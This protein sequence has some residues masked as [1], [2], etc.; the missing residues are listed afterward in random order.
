[1]A[2]SCCKFLIG[3][4]AD[5][6]VSEPICSLVNTKLADVDPVVVW[7]RPQS[8]GFENGIQLEE[9]VGVAGVV[10]SGRQT[11]QCWR[12]AMALLERHKPGCI[13]QRNHTGLY[14]K[15]EGFI[16]PF[17]EQGQHNPFQGKGSYFVNASEKR[18][19]KGLQLC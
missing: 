10:C 18:K 14:R 11:I 5:R 17:E 16:V 19:E 12:S 2:T 13:R 3:K 7:G 15:S 8:S 6:S 9:S 1:M 4:A